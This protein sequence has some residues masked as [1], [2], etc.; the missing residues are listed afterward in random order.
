MHGANR[1]FKFKRLSRLISFL[2]IAIS[3]LL[4]SCSNSSKSPNKYIGQWAPIDIRKQSTITIEK[5]GENF[6][7][8]PYGIGEVEYGHYAAS[9]NKEFDKLVVSGKPG[10][11]TD[12]I[13]D[14]KSN[15][16]IAWGNK[17]KKVESKEDT[18]SK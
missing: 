17:Y 8:T 3:L 12:I 6:T 7:V 9:Y 2:I 13:Y 16:I 4:T 5:F 10:I 15:E 14:T 11:G 18:K 1:F